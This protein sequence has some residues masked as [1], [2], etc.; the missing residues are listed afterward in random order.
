MQRVVI[1]SFST[2]FLNGSNHFRKEINPWEETKM[3][4]EKQRVRE[5]LVYAHEIHELNRAF[6]VVLFLSPLS[7]LKACFW[8]SWGQSGGKHWEAG[9]LYVLSWW[10]YL[11]EME[12][13]HAIQTNT[14]ERLQKEKMRG[15]LKGWTFHILLGNYFYL[16]E[17]T[18][19]VSEVKTGEHSKHPKLSAFMA[20]T[21]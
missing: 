12:K 20:T 7:P 8:I 1:S 21:E 11:P 6:R 13:H 15:E 17:S 19:Y 16:P 2:G 4:L 9:N 10:N 18:T 14:S 5:T 3:V